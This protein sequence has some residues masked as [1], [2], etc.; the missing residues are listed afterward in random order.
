M[1]TQE[2]VGGIYGDTV[3][4]EYNM[5]VAASDGR[6]YLV[7]EAEEKDLKRL[8]E[9]S[10]MHCSKALARDEIKVVPPQS[11]QEQDHYVSKGI[12]SRRVMCT[13]CYEKMTSSTRERVRMHYRQL[14]NTLR[15]RLFKSIANGTIR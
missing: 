6:K 12:V 9:S 13:G 4:V 10:C 8:I 3:G 7:S 5:K 2:R 11:I 14:G 1:E 15:Q